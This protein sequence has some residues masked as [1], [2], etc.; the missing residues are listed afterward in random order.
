MRST[1]RRLLQAAAATPLGL[2]PLGAASPAGPSAAVYDSLGL[3]PVINAKGFYT[4]IGGSLMPPEVRAAMDAAAGHFV[5]MNE[6]HDKAGARLAAITGAEAAMVT[7]GCSAAI[8]LGSAG[9]LTGLDPD[10]AQRLPQLD[11]MRSEA[12]IQTRHRNEFDHAVRATGLRVVAVETP[13]QFQAAF[14]ERTAMVYHLIAERHWPSHIPGQVPLTD[15]IATAK[16]HGVPVLVDAAAEVPPKRN[17]RAFLEAGADLVCFSGGKGLMG[18][19]CSGLLCGRKDLIAA[20]R[21]NYMGAG[22]DTI[23]RALKVGKEEVV[24]LLAAVERFVALDEGELI[25]EW[26]AKLER[27]AAHLQGLPGV[28]A[29]MLAE[30]IEPPHVPRMTVRWDETAR[31][32]TQ[33]QVFAAMLAGKPKVYLNGGAFGL[34]VVPSLLQ[35]GE[36]EV[37]GRRLREVLSAG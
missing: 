22:A 9:I 11:G 20:A 14:N 36:E 8:T 1:R 10:K 29:K 33:Q 30:D 21:M 26:T 7:S 34:T 28:E 17:L 2:A 31:G 5:D 15:V 18:P 13:E 37:V 23:G 3:E 4:T 27:V 16:R 35:P 19:Q 25:R 32:L 12:I 24:G 6:L